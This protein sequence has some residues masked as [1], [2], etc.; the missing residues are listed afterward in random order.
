MPKRTS[1]APVCALGHLPL[2]GKAEE[3]LIMTKQ[4]ITISR[5]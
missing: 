5:F 4:D 3:G 1:S 2:E